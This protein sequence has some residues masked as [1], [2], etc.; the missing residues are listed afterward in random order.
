VNDRRVYSVSYCSLKIS[1]RW[2]GNFAIRSGGYPDRIAEAALT[3]LLECLAAQRRADVGFDDAWPLAVRDALAGV[4][5]VELSDW[6][7]ALSGTRSAWEASYEGWPQFRRERA[8]EAVAWDE[9]RAQVQ[10]DSDCP[11]CGRDIVQKGRG[12]RKLYC[13]LR[14]RRS[15]HDGRPVKAAA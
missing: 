10:G 11:V 1:G 7:A 5:G 3:R 14:C 13:S 2:G 8:L 12:A 4:S 9:E 6:T 15:A